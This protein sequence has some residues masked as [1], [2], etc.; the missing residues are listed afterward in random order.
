MRVTSW[1]SSA[2]WCRR[3]IT[4]SCSKQGPRASSVRVRRSLNVLTKCCGR[5]VRHMRRL[6]HR[7][8]V[9]NQFGFHMR[10]Q[11]VWEVCPPSR[12]R[13]RTY[14]SVK[15]PTPPVLTSGV[16]FG[17][18]PFGKIMALARGVAPAPGVGIRTYRRIE[19]TC[20][21]QH[22]RSDQFCLE[23][24][25]LGFPTNFWKTTPWY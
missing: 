23:L 2:A 22:E 17:G 25:K 20:Q 21:R 7:C 14:R 9:K 19:T 13:K 24:P 8:S 16:A 18:K 5:S 11:E 10:A 1:C 3:R 15:L 4:S 6:V 12:C